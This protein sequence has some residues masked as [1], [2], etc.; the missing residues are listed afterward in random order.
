MRILLRLSKSFKVDFFFLFS[1]DL[2]CVLLLR[3]NLNIKAENE[4]GDL[5]QAGDRFTQVWM[6]NVQ[7]VEEVNVTK[8]TNMDSWW[9][10]REY[11][12]IIS[13]LRDGN[14]NSRRENVQPLEDDGIID[15]RGSEV[16]VG[17]SRIAVEVSVLLL[18]MICQSVLF[19]H[20]T[21]AIFL[22]CSLEPGSDLIVCS[23]CF[24]IKIE[25]EYAKNLSKLSLSPLALQEEG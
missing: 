20:L 15:A 14:E 3:E 6:L 1:A 11:E 16:N 4:P 8:G 7:P 21:K 10:R 5:L 18:K 2:F 9:G 24:R 25:E 22:S 12:G 13:I 23:L 19:F 17:F